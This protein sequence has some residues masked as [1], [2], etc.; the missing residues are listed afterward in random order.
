MR[1]EI[2][3]EIYS[4]EAVKIA[5]NIIDEDN[6][7]KIK[8]KGNKIIVET[9]NGKIFN[10]LM[11]EALNQQ[12]RIDLAKKNFKISQMILTKAFISAIANEKEENK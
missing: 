6:K 9:D 3:K 8:E 4:Y 5:K 7:I 2:N 10:E 12:C 1:Y 11:N